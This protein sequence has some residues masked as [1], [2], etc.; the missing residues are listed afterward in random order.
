MQMISA[1]M[2]GRVLEPRADRCRDARRERGT[3]AGRDERK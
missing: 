2:G 1:A 3:K